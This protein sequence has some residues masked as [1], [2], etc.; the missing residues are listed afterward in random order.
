MNKYC[1]QT[2]FGHN[3]N[4]T[5][6]WMFTHFYN[7]TNWQNKI[8]CLTKFC[9]KNNYFMIL[10]SIQYSIFI[11]CFLLPFSPQFRRISPSSIC[12]PFPP[13]LP[14]PTFHLS[15]LLCS[16]ILFSYK[17]GFIPPQLFL[18]C[19]FFS[20]FSSRKRLSPPPPHSFLPLTASSIRAIN[21]SSAAIPLSTR[22]SLIS[23]TALSLWESK[24]PAGIYAIFGGPI[25]I[26][27]SV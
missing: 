5:L 9:K 18:L 19:T 16:P 25:Q 26:L 17:W 23:L 12:P 27:Q 20:D 6:K 24:H 2:F 3:F 10:K 11:R 14:L 8:E 13:S 15:G 21:F 4:I 1:S 22:I 7:F